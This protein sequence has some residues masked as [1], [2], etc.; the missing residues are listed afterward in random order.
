MTAF[1]PHLTSVAW[2]T[3]DV[4]ASVM[5][6]PPPIDLIDWATRNVTFPKGTA[7]P[8]PYNPKDFPF[9][10]RVLEV[11]SPDHPCRIVSL[12][13]GAQLGGTV[14]AMIFACG[15]MD[16]DPAPFLFTHP[17]EP[18]AR[19]WMR[20]KF[21]PF[22]KAS[23]TL[24]RILATDR[25][26]DASA[27]GSYVERKDGRG[28]IQL[29]GAASPSSLSEISVKR[30]VQDDLSKWED[31]NGAGDPEGQADS[32]SKAYEDAKVF[33]A[34]TALVED[35]C[36]ITKNRKAGTDE[37]W[38]VACPHCNHVHALE[39]ENF[40]ANLEAAD[41]DPTRPFFTCPACS[42]RI[43]EHH[44][45]LFNDPARGARWVATH[46]ERAV[47]HVSFRV[48]SYI[49]PLSRWDEMAHDW[50]AHK[51]DPGA[52]Q[53]FYN[54]WLG[55]AYGRAGEAP[56]AE[57]LSKRAEASGLKRG[58][59]PAGFPLLAIGLDCQGDRVE[60]H[61]VA[62]GRNRR[63]VVVDYIVIG[64]HITEDE[65]RREV[66]ALV[67]SEW[68]F[69]S[70][71]RHPADVLAID[72]NAWTDD[73]YDWAKRHPRAR[74]VMVRG[75]GSDAAEII[76]PVRRDHEG[77]GR[78]RRV[79]TYGNRLYNVGVSGLKATLYE[80]LKREDPLAR[81]HVAFVSGLGDDYFEQLTAE[82]RE[83]VLTRGGRRVYRWVLK[84]GAANE[85]LDT[86]NYAEAA[87]TLKGWTRMADEAWDRLTAE[88]D[89]PPPGGR[90]LD[91]EDLPVGGIRNPNSHGANS[92]GANGVRVAAKAGAA[93]AKPATAGAGGLVGFAAR[94][95]GGGR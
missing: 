79:K 53:T 19:R 75:V 58:V 56:P 16:L 45:T 66:D 46:P 50:L 54:D 18:N 15:T 59:V 11:L 63:R 89:A 91:F 25:T 67:A 83:E 71:R 64:G 8:G 86:M 3:A 39:W 57:M 29:A 82:R 47:H 1:D 9:F 30:Q 55:L 44:R 34:G 24:R 65:T 68:P 36:R 95:N 4:E 23:E 84:K 74:V 90:Q 35:N 70:G 12:A 38:H 60:A 88:R 92:S 48:P 31:D 28:T 37:E 21:K 17:T 52:E 73:V 62:F 22:I 26:K 43:Y 20:M 72:G 76:A 94:L 27:T 5:T 32:R 10:D 78:R 77:K 6:P 61:V 42:G 69:A 14:L 81:G 7:R 2:L 41:G 49:S 40:R 33:K 80:F 85:A 93:T 87:A 13:K 51:G